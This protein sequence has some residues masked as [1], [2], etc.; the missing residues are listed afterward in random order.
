MKKRAGFF[1]GRSGVAAPRRVLELGPVV[2]TLTLIGVLGTLQPADADY[3][4]GVPEGST[5]WV[6]W[7]DQC[8]DQPPAC[9]RYHVFHSPTCWPHCVVYEATCSCF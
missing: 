9:F 2:V 4:Y 6:C 5:W 3:C 1:G 7:T 8:Q